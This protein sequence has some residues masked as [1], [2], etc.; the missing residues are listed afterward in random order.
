MF[1]LGCRPGEFAALRFRDWDRSMKPLQRITIA[2]ATHYRTREI[3]GTKTA[4]VKYVPV[5]PTL[6]KILSA[7]KLTGWSATFGR[8]PTGD[9]L[10]VPTRQ[11]LPR[12]P[13]KISQMLKRDCRVLG[14]PEHFAYAARHSFITLAQDDGADGSILRWITHAPPRT[15]F[16]GYTKMSW[17]RLCEELAKLRIELRA[18]GVLDLKAASTNE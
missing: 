4:A 11:F 14:I 9:D 1:M 5:H 15:A 17:T 7:W 8:Q 6:N 3:K 16:D 10:L 2:R 18:P 12:K 13:A